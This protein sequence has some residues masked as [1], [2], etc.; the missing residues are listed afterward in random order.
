MVAI[1]DPQ[2]L[3]TIVCNLHEDP[4][5]STTTTMAAP[6]VTTTIIV[7]MADMIAIATDSNPV[8]IATILVRNAI[9]VHHLAT[10]PMIGSA[11]DRTNIVAQPQSVVETARHHPQRHKHQ[12]RITIEAALIR[13]ALGTVAVAPETIAT[14]R[15]AD[16]A[17]PITIPW[18][19]QSD[20]CAV[21]TYRDH[22]GQ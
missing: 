14:S 5:A 7:I 4:L 1:I 3:T 13:L 9:I 12:P 11:H 19:H 20:P 2:A 15:T 22:V 18:A 16:T 6:H 10:A 21:D 17:A 8:I